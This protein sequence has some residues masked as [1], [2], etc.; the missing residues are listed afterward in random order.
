MKRILGLTAVLAM[1][2]SFVQGGDQPKPSVNYSPDWQ[3]AVHPLPPNPLH[4]LQQHQAPRQR[5][6]HPLK[7]RC[8]PRGGMTNS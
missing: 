6:Y 4:Y 3:A 5:K 2:A 8:H 1:A 7:H